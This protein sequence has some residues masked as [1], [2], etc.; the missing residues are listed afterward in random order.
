MA[1]TRGT[2]SRRT[3]DNSV[4]CLESSVYT[5]AASPGTSRN[6]SGAPP[7]VGR[8]RGRALPRRPQRV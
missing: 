3:P 6:L 2:A 8:E 1:P 7:R 4:K 5:C